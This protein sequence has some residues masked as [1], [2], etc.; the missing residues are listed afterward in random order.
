MDPKDLEEEM[1]AI[2]CENAELKNHIAL[3]TQIL[4]KN[5]RF[6]QPIQI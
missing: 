3:L 4:E 2:K 6:Y 1:E 5:V